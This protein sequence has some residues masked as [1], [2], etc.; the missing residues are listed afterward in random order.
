MAFG[1]LALGAVLL[2]A[3]AE[4]YD[5]AWS[6][7]IEL[8][9]A[10]LKDPDPARR[11]GAVHQLGQY[12][13]AAVKSYLL[14]ALGDTDR[15]VR[16]A[17]GKIL[18]ERKV[19]EA[20]PI[21]IEWLNDPD[22]AVKKVAADIL[23]D[24]GTTEAVAALIRTLG[25]VD[26]D[27]RLR[28]VIA[29]GKIGT[30][31]VVVPLVGRLE[32]DKNDVR[33]AAIEQ[34]QEIGDRRAVIPIVGAFNDPA[35]EV[36]AAAVAAVGR[37]G[38]L[39][40][41]P[42][43]LRQIDDSVDKISYNAVSSLGDL[44]AFEAVDILKDRM[45]R[46]GTDSQLR[47][48]A[49]TAL[50]KIV[51]TEPASDDRVAHTARERAAHAL[52][53][54]LADSSMTTQANEGLRIAGIAA[55]PA[56]VAHLRGEIDGDP[57]IAVTLLRDLSY[58]PATAVLIDELDRG[59]ISQS[60]VLDA[61]S[62]TGD[63]RALVPIL[64]LLSSEDAAAR[65]QAMR[66]LQPLLEPSDRAA[67]V[68]A[69]HL[70]DESF[71]VRVL[72]AEYLGLMRAK[73]SVPALVKLT[74]PGNEEALRA[75]AI[76]ALGEIGD[77]RG[78]SPL[79]A[80]LREGPASLQTAA[81]SALIYI[82]DPG[83]VAP[84][85]ALISERGDDARAQL[86]R[87][88]GGV[89]RD[90]PQAAARQALEKLARSGRL[91]V[92]IAAI[93]GLGA[94]KD[95]AA[96]GTLSRLAAN[97]EPHRRRAAIEALGALGDR[98]SASLVLDA[99]RTND[100]RVS[101]AAAWS[102]SRLG[103][104]SATAKALIAAARDR[105]WAT[106]INAAAALAVLAAREPD[107]VRPHQAELLKLVHHRHRFV[108]ANAAE[109][110]GR[111]RAAAAEKRLIAML[112]EDPSRTARAAAARAL[113]RLAPGKG[114]ARKALDAAARADDAEDVRAVAAAAGK[115]FEPVP[116]T[117]WR[118]FYFVDPDSDD[119]P[120]EQEP[121]FLIASDGLVTA[122]YTDPRGEAVEEHFPPGHYVI[123]PRTG[124]AQY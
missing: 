35:V 118:N 40:A 56:L 33:R 1:A 78:A 102:L 45:S 26:P 29:L 8:E 48:R 58:P 95:P 55:A 81:A 10:G 28:A 124:E 123:A 107:A 119:A 93:A 88:V 108:R 115:P 97:Q 65:L 38:D 46:S 90:R 76:A 47:A 70:E 75:A 67:D 39:S 101:G 49:A 7:K 12:D 68:I 37:L 50:G 121:Y 24:I 18:A 61:L 82:A 4:A 17:A 59:R 105:G 87:V 52:V 106:S 86:V 98:D 117:D 91:E 44:G 51:A 116:R 111:L 57:E 25:D 30:A 60:L 69:R 53:I 43:L 54:A 84:L 16:Q 109:A 3:P 73:A 15:N 23:S 2:A 66:A 5:F 34:L 14:A 85:L 103:S 63:K 20:A 94:M 89:L 92:A 71:E 13:T 77:Q 9:A 27:V 72:A 80:V 110:L 19:A 64:G 11:A 32:D 22:G 100:D 31:A 83:T 114:N 99:L 120:V 113:S 104:G 36:R 42:A 62:R 112:R 96:R 21:V 122:L 74:G 6:G 41:V 79:V